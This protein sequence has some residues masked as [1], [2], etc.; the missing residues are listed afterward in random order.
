MNAWAPWSPCGPHCLAADRAAGPTVGRVRRAA[1]LAGTGGM[2]ALAVVLAAMHRLLPPV[3]RRLAVRAW[4]R[5]LL[6]ALGVR[7]RVTGGPLGPGSL[8]VAN[9]ISW[10]DIPVLC[11]IQPMAMLAKQELRAWPLVG[12][13]AGRMGVLWVDRQRLRA[14]P[15][16]VGAVAGTLSAGRSVAVFAEGTTFCGVESGPFKPAMFQA[17]VDAGVPVRPVALR[18]TIGGQ[19]ARGA[20]FVGDETLWDSLRRIVA[21]RGLV[22]EAHVR[23]ALVPADLP[24]QPAPVTDRPTLVGGQPAA[25]SG[26]VAAVA[27]R[28]RPARRVL[29]AATQQSIR[30]VAAPA[31][32]PG[33]SPVV[34][35]TPVA[36]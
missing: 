24:T 7:L 11:A 26:E 8:V 32:S 30:S 20:A 1:R 10:L 33:T 2:L 17:A 9:H 3:V 34:A 23:P 36:A 12:T 22:A 4:F 31:P 13:L 29:A 18:F 35:P 19:V 25:V 14:L 15:A 16:A 28:P 27:G 6:A 21:L 5:G